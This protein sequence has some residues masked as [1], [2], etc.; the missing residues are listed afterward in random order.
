ME[1]DNNRIQVLSRSLSRFIVL[2][3]IKVQCD[4]AFHWRDGSW[5]HAFKLLRAI[6]AL[7]SVDKLPCMALTLGFIGR[8]DANLCKNMP[9]PMRYRQNC[10]CRWSIHRGREAFTTRFGLLSRLSELA[11]PVVSCV[12]GFCIL[13]AW[14]GSWSGMV[15]DCKR[16]EDLWEDAAGKYGPG[17]LVCK[18]R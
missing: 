10:A 7:T 1:V 16:R 18:Q 5:D 2:W 12:S 11:E 15:V 13:E 3:D 8:G 4:L 17:S 6:S 14:S 9:I